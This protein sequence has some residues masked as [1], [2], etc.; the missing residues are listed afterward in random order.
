NARRAEGGTYV[1][2]TEQDP[3][4]WDPQRIAEAEAILK[5][6]A[7]MGRIGALQLEAAIQSAHLDAR[8]SGARDER[9]VV[10]LYEALVQLAPT[11]GVR[12]AH[13]VALSKT[14]GPAKG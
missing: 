3:A 12:V 13:A 8:R 4:R 1:P 10:L 5:E 9:A 6:A 11:L 14:E 7:A 2:L